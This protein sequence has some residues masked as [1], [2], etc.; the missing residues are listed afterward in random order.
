M[1]TAEVLN[2]PT[3]PLPG[4][5]Q[6]RMAELAALLQRA[7]PSEG[8]H[9]TSIAGLCAIRFSTPGIE[10][11]PLVHHPALCVIAQGSKHVMLRDELYAYDAS[12]YLVFSVDLPIS[13]RIV[14]A[15]PM[16]PYLCL[17]MDIDPAEV[18]DLLLRASP[19]PAQATGARRGL[20][21]AG[22]T[23]E[24][25]DAVL[26]LARLVEAPDDAPLL[27]PLARQE[28]LFRILKGPEGAQ[29]THIGLGNTPA[30][31]VAKAIAWL[32]A[33]YR[34]PLRVEELAA[35]VHMSVSSLHHHFRTVTA[36]SPLQYQKQLR[37]QEARR[38]LLS[39]G[40]DAARVAHAVGYESRSQFSREYARCFGAPPS[41]DM[42]RLRER[43]A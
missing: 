6:D 36:M 3:R 21:L 14:H 19:A 7:T 39:G 24:M 25:L 13:S 26:R 16:Q 32:K 1:R 34:M 11:D 8:V 23:A 5:L 30:F 43:I 22:T 28:I 20:R 29:L 27:A 42:Q 12:R 10:L 18:A 4:P 17:R 37:L 33:H 40:L 38:L 9:A 15:S 31:R 35:Q 2:F 41:R